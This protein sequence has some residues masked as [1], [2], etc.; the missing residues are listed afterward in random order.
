MECSAHLLFLLAWGA[1]PLPLPFS[2]GNYALAGAEGLSNCLAF[3]WLWGGHATQL[4]P[5]KSPL[6]VGSP[7]SG[8]QEGRR[9][10]MPIPDAAQCVHILH[11]WGATPSRSHSSET[12]ASQSDLISYHFLITPATL[13]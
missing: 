6:Q 7:S 9:E 10:A 1:G 11:G 5:I 8:M 3:S 12:P 4:K 2:S 13:P